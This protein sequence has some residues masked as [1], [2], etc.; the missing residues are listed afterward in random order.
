M[1]ANVQYPVLDRG[2]FCVNILFRFLL[3][4]LYSIFID[5]YYMRQCPENCS[6]HFPS[7]NEIFVGYETKRYVD[8]WREMERGG[9]GDSRGKWEIEDMTECL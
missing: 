7:L 8:I 6:V 5:D 3:L 4:K 1:V 9:D 2:R